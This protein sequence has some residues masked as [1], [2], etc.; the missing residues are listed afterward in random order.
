QQP[1]SKEAD[2]DGGDERVYC[3]CQGQEG[4][5]MVGCDGDNCAVEWY[6]MKCVKLRKTPPGKW[7]CLACR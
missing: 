5:E 7:Y 4:G 2:P 6:H 1:S 3:T